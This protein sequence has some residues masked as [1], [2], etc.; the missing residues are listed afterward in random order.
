MI[1]RHFFG[2]LQV[3]CTS[4]IWGDYDVLTRGRGRIDPVAVIT[5]PGR[6]YRQVEVAVN[7]EVIDEGPLPEEIDSC[8]AD[9]QVTSHCWGRDE[10]GVLQVSRDDS[11]VC[12]VIVDAP[13]H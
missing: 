6:I 10:H 4:L 5:S 11:L 9:H 12:V 3:F 13:E 1:K 7:V 2:P 8:C